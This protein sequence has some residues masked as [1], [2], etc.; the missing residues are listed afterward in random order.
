MIPYKP[1]RCGLC[2]KLFSLLIFGCLY[3]SNLCIIWLGFQ[4]QA[5]L[6][7]IIG[8]FGLYQTTC[9]FAKTYP[10]WFERKLLLFSYLVMAGGN[11]CLNFQ[12]ERMVFKLYPSTRHSYYFFVLLH[13]LIKSLA[14]ILLFF[15]ANLDQHL[16]VLAADLAPD[17][18]DAKAE[19]KKQKKKGGKVEPVVQE[20]PEIKPV[21][22]QEVPSF[23]KTAL[24]VIELSAELLWVYWQFELG[25]VFAQEEPNFVFAQIYHLITACFLIKYLHVFNQNLKATNVDLPQD[26]SSIAGRGLTVHEPGGKAFFGL[27]TFYLGSKV[28]FLA[29]PISITIF[30]S[31]GVIMVLGIL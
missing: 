28:S 12:E 23:F 19:E 20:S 7:T 2:Y 10:N 9:D 31:G 3:I 13:Y 21:P 16:P 18:Q 27:L 30:F 6:F 22:L 24:K 17:V 25:I 8:M 11:C 14:L 1:E 5:I 26:F 29:S 4:K 15:A